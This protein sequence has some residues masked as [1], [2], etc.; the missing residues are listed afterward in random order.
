[1]NVIDAL[2]SLDN[3]L[4]RSDS[5]WE[6]ESPAVALLSLKLAKIITEEPPVVGVAAL[7]FLIKRHVKIGIT[8]IEERTGKGEPK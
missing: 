8:V 3:L 4:D 2:K 1:M 5:A 7:L 6:T